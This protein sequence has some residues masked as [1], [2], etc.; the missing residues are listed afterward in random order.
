[1]AYCCI[2]LLIVVVVNVA[3]V[4]VGLGE[5]P[6]GGSENIHTEVAISNQACA[7]G[8]G[9]RWALAFPEILRL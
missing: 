9:G 4:V 1:M 5:Y 3:V 2:E 7:A 6:Y 8:G